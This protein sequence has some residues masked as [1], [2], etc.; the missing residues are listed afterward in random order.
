MKHRTSPALAAGLGVVRISKGL[1]GLGPTGWPYGLSLS[2][3]ILLPQPSLGDPSKCTSLVLIF[4]RC[5]SQTHT[6]DC[7]LP[8]LCISGA[9][10]PAP[11][12]NSVFSHTPGPSQCSQRRPCHHHA[13]AP[14]SRNL[15]ITLE[16]SLSFTAHCT[17]R[18][19]P[20]E[21]VKCPRLVCF[22]P[23][24]PSLQSQ[25]QD[26]CNK[27]KGSVSLHGLTLPDSLASCWPMLLI[28]FSAQPPWPP[29]LSW[30][31]PHSLYRLQYRPLCLQLIVPSPP[32]QP[33]FKSRH[34]PF[35][36]TSDS[37]L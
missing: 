11:K 4:P 19:L 20:T 14:H 16:T 5:K 28:A 26:S 30:N 17:H 32:A 13:S 31:L 10:T 33:P 2:S 3:D 29:L 22:S 37:Q 7:Q 21:P 6:S 24:A 27:D 35:L 1:G 18:G 36:A 23:L 8:P 12:Q 9:L 15:H 25:L 34:Q